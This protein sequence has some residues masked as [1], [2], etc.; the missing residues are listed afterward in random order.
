MSKPTPPEPQPLYLVTVITLPKHL[1]LGI[2]DITCLIKTPKM[3]I[4]CHF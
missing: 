4:I 3:I 2:C 1:N